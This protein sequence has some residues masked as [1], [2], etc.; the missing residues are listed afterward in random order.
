ML[1][2]FGY[3]STAVSLWDSS[4]AKT[5]TFKRY[6][7]LDKDERTGKLHNVTRR[8]LQNTMRMLLYNAAHEIFVY[9]LSSSIVP[10]ATHPDVLWD[11]VTPFKQQWNEIGDFIKACNMR[12]SFH[13]N[14]FTLFTSPRAEITA[15]SVRDLEFHYRMLTAMG[16]EDTSYMNIHVGGAYGDKQLSIERFHENIRQLPEPIKERLTLEN[17][18]KTYTATETLE[19]CSKQ[20]IPLVFD[21]H[22]HLANECET[23][24]SELLPYI[25]STWE[26]TGLP[27]KIH[28]SSPKSDKAFRS[29]ADYV[30]PVFLQPLLEELKV[31]N[32]DVDFMVEAKSKDIALLQLVEDLSAIRGIKRVGGATLEI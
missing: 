17:D 16:V 4:P 19:V 28:I 13:P 22:H 5:M 23:G 18:D 27:P 20:N 21:F 25:F 9:R 8:N 31:V 14:Q 2:R 3:V 26:R 29:H 12:V 11:F 6:E 32:K 1:I 24:L 10:L 30:D 7:Q 15:N